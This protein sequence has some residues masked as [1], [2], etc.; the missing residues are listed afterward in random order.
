MLTG[1]KQMTPELSWS[2]QGIYWGRR[3]TLAQ[4]NLENWI[5]ASRQLDVPASTN[6]Y[7]FSSFGST[8]EIEIQTIARR[9]ILLAIPLAVF[10]LGILLLY[11]RAIRHPIALFAL[12][13]IIAAVG[14]L[15]PEP[16]LQVAQVA[17]I[18]LIFV[19]AMGVLK[20][21][22]SR[23]RRRPSA[24]HGTSVSHVDVGTTQ[25]RIPVSSS[26]SQ[27]TKSTSDLSVHLSESESK[28]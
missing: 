26:D 10:L 12:G 25:V 27:S 19:L 3:A 18:G 17:G 9:T 21:L 16:A 2:W 20:W 11:V 24:I 13:L 7:L 1:P 22:F 6:Q 14:L 8:R 5:G 28:A 23:S 15:Y 4:R